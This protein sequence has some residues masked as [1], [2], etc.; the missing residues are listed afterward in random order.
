MSWVTK[1]AVTPADSRSAVKVFWAWLRVIASSAPNGSSMSRISGPA[2][3]ARAM[4]TRWR[5]PP[6]SSRGYRSAKTAGSSPAA[7]RASR[8][9]S[10]GLPRPCRAGTRLALAR[11]VQCGISPPSCWT[12]P[13]ERRSCTG[14]IESTGSPRTTTLPRSSSVSLLMVRSRVVF[15]EPLSPTNATHAPAST[16]SVTPSRATVAPYRFTALS[17]LIRAM[18]RRPAVLSRGGHRPRCPPRSAPPPFLPPTR[19]RA[20]TSVPRRPRLRRAR[21]PASPGS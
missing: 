16:S 13:I 12:Y 4:A 8:P 9:C 17:M 14:S 7:W 21:P 2:A 15:P 10:S 20:H 5:C 3:M 1:M 6:D 19:V 18:G 11:H